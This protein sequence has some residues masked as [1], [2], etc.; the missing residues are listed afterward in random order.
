MRTHAIILRL[1]ERPGVVAFVNVGERCTQ[2]DAHLFR[3]ARERRVRRHD[4]VV[5]RFEGDRCI[6]VRGFRHF[7]F[8]F[9][10]YRN[11]S[12]RFDVIN[13]RRIR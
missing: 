5:Q 13:I 7:V 10:M 9:R 2:R 1:R 8:R 11:A 4:V 3:R 6:C 12:L